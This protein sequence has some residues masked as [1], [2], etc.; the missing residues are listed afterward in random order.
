MNVRIYRYIVT[1]AACLPLHINPYD[2]DHAKESPIV[3]IYA[4]CKTVI[5]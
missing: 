2:K 1:W 5:T 3:Y 4:C